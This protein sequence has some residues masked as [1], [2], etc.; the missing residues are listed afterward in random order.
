MKTFKLLK[1]FHPIDNVNIDGKKKSKSIHNIK[2]R[3][4]LKNIDEDD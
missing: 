1:I 4:Y 2:S 3:K